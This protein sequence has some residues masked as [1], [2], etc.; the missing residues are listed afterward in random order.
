VKNHLDENGKHK[1]ADL[2]PNMQ[3]SEAATEDTAHNDV[4]GHGN[5]LPHVHHHRI[6]SLG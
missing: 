3:I 6:S 2:H 5:K 1:S 4:S